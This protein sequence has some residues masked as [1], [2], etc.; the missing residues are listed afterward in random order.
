MDTKSQLLQEEGLPRTPGVAEMAALWQLC[1]ANVHA[2]R[3]LV[4]NGC[5]VCLCCILHTLIP[6]IFLHALCYCKAAIG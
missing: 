4:L 3:P 2:G 5:R 1:N 6:Q